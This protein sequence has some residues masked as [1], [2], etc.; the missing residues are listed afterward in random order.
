MGKVDYEAYLEELL[1]AGET[2]SVAQDDADD[3][4]LEEE[5][6][7]E[8][9]DNRSGEESDSLDE[10]VESGEVKEKARRGDKKS[11]FCKGCGEF[12]IWVQVGYFPNGVRRWKDENGLICNGRFCG[13][14]QQKRAKKVM[15]KTREK[16]FS[17]ND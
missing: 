15:A 13:T 11:V 6:I 7:D 4:L 8:A 14:C 12:G 17:P 10:E 16:R 9:G 2:Q 5:L 3:D 1:K